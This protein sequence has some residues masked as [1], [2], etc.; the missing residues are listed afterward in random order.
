MAD[1]VKPNQNLPKSLGEM[2]GMIRAP[3]YPTIPRQS[4]NPKAW[5]IIR[6]YSCGIAPADA[7]PVNTDSQQRIRF[8]LP[9]TFLSWN[10]GVNISD[11]SGFPM[12]WD[13]LN[14]FSVKFETENGEL[15]TTNSRLAGSVLGDGRRMGHVG[16]SGWPF[17][18]GSNMVVTITPRLAGLPNGVFLRIDIS[19]CCLET[20]LGSSVEAQMIDAGHAVK[21]V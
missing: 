21:N 20:R 1:D 5:S 8:S 9:T 7:I 13:P 17:T 4:T 2:G 18:V 14:T 3:W 16:G 10:G 15:I 19:C 11:G 6:V 12:G